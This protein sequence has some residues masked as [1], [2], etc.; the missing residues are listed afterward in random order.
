MKRAGIPIIY[1]LILLCIMILLPSVALAQVAGKITKVEGSVDILKSG[2]AAAVPI[3]LNDSISI[4][5]ILRTKSDGKAEITFIDNS[6]MTVGPKSRLGIEE[7]LFKPEAEKRAVSVKLHRGKMGFNVPKP[8]YSAE[9][10]KFEM[11]TRSAVAGIRGTTGILITGIQAD[12]L[13]ISNGLGALTNRNGT[14]L[15]TPGTVAESF[16]GRPPSTRPFSPS[17]FN[18]HQSSLTIT[19]RPSGGQGQGS[20]GQSAGGAGAPL[21]GDV[22]AVPAATGGRGNLGSVPSAVVTGSGAGA[23]QNA[24]PPIPINNNPKII[25]PP[26]PAPTPAPTN[27]NVNINVNFPTP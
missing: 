13:Y 25:P 2:T 16:A 9:G 8:V 23:P 7:Y 27:S 19:P 22:P 21:A 24:I 26:A 18:S 15:A 11:K 4:G 1:P 10:S 17:E 14:A 5:D 3:K 6:V 20:G 12:R